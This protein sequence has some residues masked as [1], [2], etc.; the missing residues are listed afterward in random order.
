[1]NLT[2]IRFLRPHQPRQRVVLELLGLRRI[3]AI[4]DRSD[5]VEAMVQELSTYGQEVNLTPIRLRSEPDP[6][7]LV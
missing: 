4:G 2:P 6:D 1:M 5:A 7:T 3:D